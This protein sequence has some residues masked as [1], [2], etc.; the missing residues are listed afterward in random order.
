MPSIKLW[1]VGATSRPKLGHNF[2]CLLLLPRLV[3]SLAPKDLPLL[4]CHHVAPPGVVDGIHV[5]ARL[6]T[7]ASALAV[8][9]TAVDPGDVDVLASV[10]LEGRLGAVHLEMQLRDGMAELGQ[11]AQWQVARV[12]RDLG[13][14][15]LH[16]EDVVDVRVRRAQQE[17][18]C[19]LAREL[20]D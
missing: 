18:L 9:P 17:W 10:E 1:Q 5:T 13:R 4:Q 19:D 12:K 7:E 2:G 20:L 14:I 16:D 3:H 15:S 6:D 11:L 8:R